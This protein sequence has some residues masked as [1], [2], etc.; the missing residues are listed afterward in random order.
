MRNMFLQMV[1][2]KVL[3]CRTYDSKVISFTK[4]IRPAIGA[5]I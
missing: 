2:E 3:A 4:A 5:G 1:V